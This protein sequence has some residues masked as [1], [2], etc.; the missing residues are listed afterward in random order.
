[1]M[2]RMGAPTLFFLR[3]NSLSTA[4]LVLFSAAHERTRSTPC[5]GTTSC[6]L[7]IHGSGYASAPKSF[8]AHHALGDDRPV[9]TLA[10]PPP[11]PRRTRLPPIQVLPTFAAQ[12]LRDV[13]RRFPSSETEVPPDA[14]YAYRRHPPRATHPIPRRPPTHAPTSV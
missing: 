3:M 8:A 11:D 13:H 6:L 12:E 14:G 7:F 1:M 10:T 4:A 5:P 9:F 2:T